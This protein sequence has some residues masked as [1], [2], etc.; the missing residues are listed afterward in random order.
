MKILFCALLS[1]LLGSLSPAAFFSKLKNQNLRQEGTGNLGA[2]NTFLV[3]GKK[4]GVAVMLFD[5]AKAYISVK[6]GKVLAPSVAAAGVIAGGFAIVGHIFPFY[7]KFKG[8]KG[9]ASFGGMILALDPVVFIELAIIAVT[10]IFI[11]NYTVAAP[12]SASILFPIMYSVRHF[13]MASLLLLIAIS[14]LIITV[15]I[16]NI[17]RVKRGDDVK[18]REYVKEHLFG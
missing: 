15:H 8:G 12:I 14:V 6:I 18:M 13:D 3:I 1:Y 9:L 17:Y 4:Y 16:P 7:M 2:T 5:V 10:L 11:V